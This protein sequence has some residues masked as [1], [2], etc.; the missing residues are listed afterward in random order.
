MVQE[1]V[2]DVLAVEKQLVFLAH[3]VA[4]NDAPENETDDVVAMPV[5]GVLQVTVNDVKN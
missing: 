2:P 5:D 3:G 1:Y 4:A